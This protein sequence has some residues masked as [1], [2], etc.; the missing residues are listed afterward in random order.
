MATSSIP[1]YSGP[2]PGELLGKG[3][4][5]VRIALRRLRVIPRRCGMNP[6]GPRACRAAEECVGPFDHLRRIRRPC[7]VRTCLAG[8]SAQ[9]LPQRRTF[10]EVA[11]TCEKPGTIPRFE[12]QA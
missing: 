10:V 9:L 8:S 7:T 6:R 11:D 3:R 12:Q 1:N 4:M 5:V 2:V